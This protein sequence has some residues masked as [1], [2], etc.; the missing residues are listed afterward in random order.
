MVPCCLKCSDG[1]ASFVVDAFVVLLAKYDDESGR[2]GGESWYGD[3]GLAWF[4]RIDYSSDEV[5][6]QIRI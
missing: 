2:K 5:Q 6:M 3:N 4:D 1:A